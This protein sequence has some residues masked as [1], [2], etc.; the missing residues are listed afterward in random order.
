MAKANVTKSVLFA[1]RENLDVCDNNNQM[2]INQV[3]LPEDSSALSANIEV[4]AAE[5]CHA[6][7]SGVS[8]HVRWHPKSTPQS[9]SSTCSHSP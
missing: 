3:Q 8:S 1:A 9:M 7:L 4:L 2:D 6:R 5:W